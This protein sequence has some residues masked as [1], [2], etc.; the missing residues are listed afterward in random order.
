MVQRFELQ[1]HHSAIDDDLSGM[2]EVH[3]YAVANDRLHLSQPPIG[4]AGMAHQ[5][6]DFQ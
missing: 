3:R 1:G 6:A 5:S 4:L 2:F